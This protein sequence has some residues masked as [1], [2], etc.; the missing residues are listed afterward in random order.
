[1][2]ARFIVGAMG[3]GANLRLEPLRCPRCSSTIRTENVRLTEYF[4]CPSCDEALAVSD[5]YRLGTWSLTLALSVAISLWLTG[6][7]FWHALVYSEFEWIGYVVL[8][9]LEIAGFGYLTMSLI[10]YVGKYWC[11]PQLIVLTSAKTNVL[12]LNG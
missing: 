10:A 6:H 9:L 4:L 1:H 12:G 8:L 11:K 3:M 7:R 2:L 5:R